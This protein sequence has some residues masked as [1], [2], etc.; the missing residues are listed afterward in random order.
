M[1][2][3]LSSQ[4]SKLLSQTSIRPNHVTTLAL[5]MGVLAGVSLA[6][7]THKSFLVGALCLHISFILDNCDGELA[8][9]TGL[10]SVFGARYD[11]L[12]DL[13]TDCA[14]W[15][16]LAFGVMVVKGSCH[17]LWWAGF[18]CLGSILNEVMVIWERKKGCC[19]S[20][21][22]KSDIKLK[23]KNNLF[24]KILDFVSHN[25]DIIFLVWLAALIG[26]MAITLSV[27][28]IYINALWLWRFISH[29]KTLLS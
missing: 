11:L 8:R 28:C 17:A 18:A 5:F 15:I 7:G 2:R 24:L 14:L 13:V 3:L 19:T 10:E 23:R 26:D 6:G 21:H 16:G 20:I 9:L 25:G 29:R 1:N 27:G 12:A 4:I 22:S